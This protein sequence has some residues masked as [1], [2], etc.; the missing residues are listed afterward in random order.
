MGIYQRRSGVKCKFQKEG[1]TLNAEVRRQESRSL[2]LAQCFSI[3]LA[4]WLN[5]DY[6]DS[7]HP[8]P[9]PPSDLLNQNP[10]GMGPGSLTFYLV[11]WVHSRDQQF[12]ES[13]PEAQ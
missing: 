12:W 6:W 5:T 10:Q 7:L 2:I 13:W 3:R 4:C 9:T 8:I 11:P 1:A